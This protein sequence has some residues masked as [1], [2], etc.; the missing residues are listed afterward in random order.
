RIERDVFVAVTLTVVRVTEPPQL[1]A[2]A[3]QRHI[4]G[5]G[6]IVGIERQMRRRGSTQRSRG[7]QGRLGTAQLEAPAVVVGPQHRTVESPGG[8]VALAGA[9]GRICRPDGGVAAP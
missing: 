6:Y 4:A 2:I 9:A 8:D 7:G 5:D 1:E 3:L